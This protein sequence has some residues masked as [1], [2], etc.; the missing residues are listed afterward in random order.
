MEPGPILDVLQAGAT[1]AAGSLGVTGAS[2]A[3]LVLAGLL[4]GL[5]GVE[6]EVSGHPAGMRTHILV[7]GGSALVMAVS[8]AMVNVPWQAAAGSDASIVVSVDPG[9]IAYGVMTGVGFLG[10]GAILRRGSRIHGLTTAAGVWATAAIGLAAGLGQYVLAVGATLGLLT[11]LT[12]LNVIENRL[13]R[14]HRR[15]IRVT[16]ERSADV[17]ERFETLIRSVGRARVGG[18][19][20]EPPPGK[21]NGKLSLEIRVIYFGRRWWQQARTTLMATD[22]LRV[23]QMT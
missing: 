4:G 21:D 20:I 22:W 14:W 12:M 8:V 6:R 15:R 11:T 19:R 23:E 13:P 17:A 2:L 18:V 3:K 1:D 5:V 10:A 16:V 9:R 7:C